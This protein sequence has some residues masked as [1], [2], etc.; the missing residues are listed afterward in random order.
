M[1]KKVFILFA[2]SFLLGCN[3]KSEEIISLYS[4]K[5]IHELDNNYLLSDLRLVQAL[6]GRLFFNDWS[7]SQILILDNKLQYKNHFGNRGQGPG[8]FQWIGSLYAYND[9]IYAL[10][11]AGNRI[12]IY[13]NDGAFIRTIQ[14]DRFPIGIT[15][16]R[17]T[18]I[19]DQLITPASI[20]SDSDLLIFDINSSKLL[21]EI[22][23]NQN[24]GVASINSYIVS[25]FQDK[26]ILVNRMK[27][28]VQMLN[29]E[30]S[31]VDEYDLTKI[32]ELEGL[33][34]HYESNKNQ[35]NFQSY[36]TFIRDAY[37][38]GIYLYILC[39]PWP[40]RDSYA[41]IIR[42]SLEEN[43][44][45]QERVFKIQG[46]NSSAIYFRSIAVADDILY[47]VEG[48]NMTINM[49]HLNF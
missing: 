1:K 2:L 37:V 15:N 10:D 42:L 17:F 6:N 19:N 46:T 14:P 26:V 5:S 40:G 48:S 47:A 39:E 27:P 33:W 7:N 49:F 43:R 11:D 8:E 38:D 22:K 12:H 31:L 13:S 32:K 16:L 34:Q 36:T 3:S 44:I 4:Q 28:I 9:N 29:L 23:F 30:G 25:S 41:Y 24:G 20:Y 18:V 21:Q 45:K 35:T